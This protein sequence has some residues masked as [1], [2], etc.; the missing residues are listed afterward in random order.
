MRHWTVMFIPHDTESP[1]SISVSGRVLRIAASAALVIALVALIGLGSIIA[2]LGDFGAAGV[3]QA[4]GRMRDAVE[5]A[6]TADVQLLRQQVRALN[7]TLDTIRNADA[8]LRAVAGV[9]NPDTAT[10]LRRWFPRIALFRRGP[11]AS[12]PAKV[13]VPPYADSAQ[14]RSAIAGS[15]AT[16]DSLQRHAAAVAERFGTLADSAMAPRQGFKQRADPPTQQNGSG[17]RRP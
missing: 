10:L 15:R 13:I 4:S 17:A 11:R 14:L 8:R 6:P 12:M 2:Q 7:G 9:V 16:T 1:R 5:A 3:T